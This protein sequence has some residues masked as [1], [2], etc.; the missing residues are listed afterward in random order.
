MDLSFIFS[1]PSTL[2]YPLWWRFN[3]LTGSYSCTFAAWQYNAFWLRQADCSFQ[4][5]RLNWLPFIWFNLQIISAGSWAFQ[6]YWW[7]PKLLFRVDWFQQLP[8][9][10]QKALSDFLQ[11]SLQTIS[12][13]IFPHTT[14]ALSILRK[15]CHQDS[16]LFFF[17]DFSLSSSFHRIQKML[18][19]WACR[20]NETL[21]AFFRSVA[22]WRYCR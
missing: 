12:P 16:G 10:G 1:P 6:C 17:D 22:H 15:C 4:W 7:Y 21:C 8:V 2:A 18:T 9:W 5:L 13:G 11:R 19:Y 20:F 14:F 3:S